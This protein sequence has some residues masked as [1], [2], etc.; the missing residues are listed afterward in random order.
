VP[1]LPNAEELYEQAACGL[2]LT[3]ARG[4]ILKA[5]ATFCGWIGWTAQDIVGR[6][7]QE[8]FTMGGRIF[9]QTHWQ[10][11]LELQGS[12]AEVKL[13]L[14]HAKGHAVPMLLNVLRLERGGE[15]F[16]QVSA[17]VAE[18]RNR[19]ERELL[20]ARKRAD[21]S[22]QTQRAAQDALRL[23]E[24]RLRQALQVGEL[25][26]WEVDPTS[27]ARRL[28]DD[29]ALLLGFGSARQLSEADYVGAIH[30]EDRTAEAQALQR[31]LEGREEIYGFTYRLNGADGIQRVI[32]SAGQGFFDE[33]GNLVR[34]VGVLSD[35]TELARE[36]ASAEDRAL[37]AEQMIGIVS[38]DLRNPLSAILMGVRLLGR[39]DLPASKQRV[40]GH[41]ASSA[42]RARRLIEDLLDFTLARVGAGLTVVR[43]PTNIQELVATVVEELSL[44]FPERLI[45]HDHSGPGKA[46]IDADRI[47]QILSNLVGN[48]MTYGAPQSP[49]TV[50]SKVSGSSL[51]ISVHNLGPVI[52][53][54][55][56]A[57]LFE[58]MVRGVPGTSAAK[59]VGLGLFIVREIARAHRGEVQVVSTARSGTTFTVTMPAIQ[60]SSTRP[61]T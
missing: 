20:A 43:K 14:N 4:L 30:P 6:K 29:V 52:P 39:G 12:L 23:S 38:H 16:D 46:E 13:E 24:A 19:Y 37:L 1:D 42:E 53:P 25:Y 45:T 60:Q 5:N 3:D 9:H 35:V 32:K 41:V 54:K 7:L 50:R 59:S 51:S 28:G 10:P 11:M 26:L 2:L 15:V 27:R 17:M 61:T 8:L 36:R 31:V 49:V 33:S 21:E 48:A 40:L 44:S 55:K 22:L 58:P 57:S 18:D 34:F 56:V 47:A